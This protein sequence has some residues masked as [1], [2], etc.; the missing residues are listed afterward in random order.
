MKPDKIRRII[1]G[2]IKELKK[3]GK[4]VDGNFEKD[5]LH[6]FREA[7]VKRLELE[8]LTVRPSG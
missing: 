4:K 2:K 7:A 5:A 3:L 6:E 1:G 8:R